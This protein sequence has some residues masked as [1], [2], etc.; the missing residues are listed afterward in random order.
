MV[1]VADWVPWEAE[2]EMEISM[3]DSS[4]TV[5]GCTAV[6]GTRAGGA[7]GKQDLGR[8]GAEMQ[9]SVGCNLGQ[10]SQE[11]RRWDDLSERC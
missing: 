2:S 8:G 5:L 9:S 6:A 1:I 10:P 4:G 3:Q 7:G 11:I